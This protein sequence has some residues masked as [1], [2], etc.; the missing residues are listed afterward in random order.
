MG[1]RTGI[2]KNNDVTLF[3]TDSHY[4]TI[5]VITNEFS[6]CWYEIK[7]GNLVTLIIWDQMDHGSYFLALSF[8]FAIKSPKT[9]T[10]KR[11]R[12]TTNERNIKI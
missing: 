8:F 4:K 2:I 3:R 9:H 1:I 5:K 7:K 10:N 11:V 6:F 12:F